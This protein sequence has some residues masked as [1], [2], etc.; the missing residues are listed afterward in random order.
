MLKMLQGIPG[1]MTYTYLATDESQCCIGYEDGPVGRP[2]TLVKGAKG[3]GDLA[4]ILFGSKAEI[5]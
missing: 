4:D 5:M 2:R 3:I 1:N